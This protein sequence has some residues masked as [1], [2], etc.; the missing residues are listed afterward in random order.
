MWVHNMRVCFKGGHR[1]DALV[2]WPIVQ[3]KVTNSLG[4]QLCEALRSKCCHETTSYICVKVAGGWSPINV[5]VS[6]LG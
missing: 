6:C 1:K 4:L 2:G 5:C 3:A